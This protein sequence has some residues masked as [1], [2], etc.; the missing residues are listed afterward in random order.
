MMKTNLLANLANKTFAFATVM[1]MGLAFVACQSDDDKNAGEDSK[2]MIVTIDNVDKKV[3]DAEYKNL[4]NNYWISLYLSSDRT[5]SVEFYLNIG[6]HMDKDI[7]LTKVQEI[8]GPSWRVVYTIN[9]GQELIVSDGMKSNNPKLFTDG[10]LRF[11]GDPNE[12]FT[13]TLTNGNVLGRDNQKHTIQI[14]YKATSLNDAGFVDLGLNVKWAADNV[15]GNPGFR[16]AWGEIAS[17]EMNHWGMYKWKNANKMSLIKYCTDKN[18]GQVDGLTTLQ[19]E[20]DA[21]T[22]F[23]QSPR[24]RMPTKEEFEELLDKC[25]WTWTTRNNVKGYEVK[26]TNGSSIFMPATFNG[27]E[28]YYLAYWSSTLNKEDCSFAHLLYCWNSKGSDNRKT[29]GSARAFTNLIRAVRQ[30]LSYNRWHNPKDYGQ[31]HFIVTQVM[32]TKTTH[33]QLANNLHCDGRNARKRS[34]FPTNQS[35]YRAKNREEK[36]ENDAHSSTN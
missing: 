8:K 36:R 3:V 7:N 35:P 19:P 18:V 25:T 16:Y 2:P 27:K 20:D 5:E 34:A 21:A 11:E 13:I 12:T 10:K 9:D 17:K 24:Y 22:N 28:E 6:L 23:Y 1:M 32:Q 15:G 30:Q 33:Q 31:R 26:G 14:S 4:G 29:V